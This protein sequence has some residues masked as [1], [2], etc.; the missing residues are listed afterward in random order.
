MSSLCGILQDLNFDVIGSDSNENYFTNSALK[1]RGIEIKAFNLENIKGDRVYIISRAYNKDNN[2]EVRKII[3]NGF[4][5]YYYNEFIE[6]FF[7][8][9]KIGISGTHGKTTVTKM[10]SHFLSDFKICSLI[11]DST[12]YGEENYKYFIL[13]ACEYKNTFLEYTYDYLVINNIDYDHVDF[14][15]NI[16][17]VYES[18][19]LASKKAKCLIVN[20]DDPYARKIPHSNKFSFGFNS[21]NDLIITGLKE[22]KNGYIVK[23]VMKEY[24]KEYLV[25]FKGKHNLYNFMASLLVTKLLNE[26]IDY[27]EKLYSFKFPTK[28]MEEKKYK[29][30][31][32]IND[33]AHHPNEIISLI[34][35]VKSLYPDKDIISIFQPH[36][37]SR[38]IK[39][40]DSFKKCF[41]GSKEV[42]Y[43]ETFT[44]REP[45]NLEKEKIVDE[46]MSG[47]QKINIDDLKR[48]KD[49]T[50]SVI[51]FL[52]AGKLSYEMILN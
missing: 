43:V 23:A 19:Y 7:K 42:Y 14:F 8:G 9:I 28:R 34:E 11:G 30:N 20:G 29:T 25:P 41:E 27:Q 6:K 51:L 16:E 46:I 45:K 1:A 40:K 31:I 17:E 50:N 4:V 48:F 15:N 44:S 33:Y 26:N 47:Y 37:Y 2:I 5:Y 13:E 12:G 35:M 21:D 3:E 52:G 32:Y 22:Y 38:T 10:V 39:L 18:F 36:T 24:E 49:Y